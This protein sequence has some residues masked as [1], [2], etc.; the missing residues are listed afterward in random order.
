M[1]SSC[2][3]VDT[4]PREDQNHGRGNRSHD[5]RSNPSY[6]DAVKGSGITWSR[7]ERSH[8]HMLYFFGFTSCSL[9]GVPMFEV[10]PKN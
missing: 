10:N 6:S 3:M 4:R 8:V 9:R 7:P 5:N 2:V 1:G